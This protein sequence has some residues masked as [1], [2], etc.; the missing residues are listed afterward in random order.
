VRDRAR[1]SVHLAADGSPCSLL[2]WDTDFWRVRIGRVE[3]DVLS[4]ELVARIDRWADEHVAACVYFLASGEDPASV[5]A[6]ED[7][8]FHLMD[9]R[10]ELGRDAAP[11]PAEGLRLAREEDREILRAIARSSHGI[12]RFYADPRFPNDRCDDLYA[13]WIERSLD[14]WA[15]AVLV[16]EAEGVASGYVSVHLDGERGSIGLIAVDER[17][18][19]RGLGEALSRG[20]VDWCAAAGASSVSVVT[21]GRNAAALRTF[22]RAG[23]RT[24]SVGLWFHKWYER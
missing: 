16:V 19:G 2:Q 1:R 18:R 5:H 7:A 20:A 14:G 6:A 10:T 11:G 13:T 22:E 15:Q 24:Q 3:G 21:Q 8:G 9:L 4:S 12:T 17:A 23:F